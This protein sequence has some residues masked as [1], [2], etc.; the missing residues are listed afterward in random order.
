MSTKWK[1][2]TVSGKNK[3]ALIFDDVHLPYFSHREAKGLANCL[4]NAAP[5][6][7]AFFIDNE[8]Y[9]FLP[10][11]DGVTVS[12]QLK[13][14]EYYVPVCELTNAQARQI[15]NAINGRLAIKEPA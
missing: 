2:D 10:G 7:V 9:R 12:I 5:G 1:L 13:G 4:E 11:V 8:T 6:N 14:T 15:A 3:F